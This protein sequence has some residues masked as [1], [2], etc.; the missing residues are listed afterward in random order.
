MKIYIKY[1][2][3][4][5]GVLIFCDLIFS[6]GI[7]IN[8]VPILQLYYEGATFFGLVTQNILYFLLGILV[9]FTF[10]RQMHFAK[11]FLL[12]YVALV[13]LVGLISWS[14]NT[15]F[16]E[17]EIKKALTQIETQRLNDPF[18][19]TNTTTTKVYVHPN[20]IVKFVYIIGLL[21][22]FM[23]RPCYNE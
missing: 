11:W 15:D 1:T 8:T 4:L 10:A 18:S 3:Y 23:V 20:W 22:A 16:A 19:T 2:D 7:L 21:Y 6:A 9:I 5:L 17:N 14:P 13:F 12:G